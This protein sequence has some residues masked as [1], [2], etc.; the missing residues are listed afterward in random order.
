[1]IGLGLAKTLKDAKR[2]GK[3][4]EITDFIDSL[5]DAPAHLPS[6]DES[7]QG[8]ENTKKINRVLMGLPTKEVRP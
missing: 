7:Q 5:F 3:A 2:Q 6:P 4:A 1:M 8:D